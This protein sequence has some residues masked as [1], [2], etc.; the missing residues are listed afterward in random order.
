MRLQVQSL[1]LLSGFLAWEAPYAVG[2]AL[3]KIK[4]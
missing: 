2:V 4:K 3:E 1:A